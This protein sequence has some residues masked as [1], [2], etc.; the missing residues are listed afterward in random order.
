MYLEEKKNKKAQKS[1]RKAEGNYKISKG[2][3]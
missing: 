1:Q 2:Y 3:S